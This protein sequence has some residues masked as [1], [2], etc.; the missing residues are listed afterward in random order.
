MASFNPIQVKQALEEFGNTVIGEARRNL[1]ARGMNASRSLSRNLDFQ[2]Q[3]MKN[4]IFAYFDLGKYGLAQDQGVDGTQQSQGSPYRYSAKGP[5]PEMVSNIQSWM[6]A[7]G[8]GFEELNSKKKA[9]KIADNIIKRGLKRTLFFSEAY[10]RA[11]AELPEELVEA[12][13][14]D[15]DDFFNF[16]IKE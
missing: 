12:F 10:E 4:S 5:S 2:S 13:G 1:E 6:S 8:I 7:R 3:V 9:W 14:L 15:L 16:I 11:F